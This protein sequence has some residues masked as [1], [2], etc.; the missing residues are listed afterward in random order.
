MF[1]LYSYYALVVPFL[2]FP[3]IDVPS[4]KGSRTV[5]NAKEREMAL[6]LAQLAV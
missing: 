4:K 1:L 3:P 6:C 2:G 5:A